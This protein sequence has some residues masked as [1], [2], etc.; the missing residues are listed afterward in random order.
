MFWMGVPRQEIPR[1]KL[2]RTPRRIFGRTW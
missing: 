1:A 2:R